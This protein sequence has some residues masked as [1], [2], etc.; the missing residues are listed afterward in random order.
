MGVIAENIAIV[1]RRIQR[2][3]EKAGRD[4]EEI[5]L[6]AVSKKV[7]A[8]RIQEALEAGI[9][10]FGENYVQEARE[11]IPQV[12]ADA[13]WH[14]VGHVQTNKAK[15]VVP[16]FVLIHSV[17]TVKLAQEISRQAEKLDK[18]MDI[19]IQVNISG[20]ESKSGVGVGT[21]L[22]LIQ[23]AAQL[24]HVGIQGL[25]TMPPFFDEPERA[26]PFFR[27]LRE[28]RDQLLPLLPSSVSLPHLSM[29]MSGDFE[30][31]V[32]EGATLVRIGTAIFGERRK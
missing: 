6:V 31:A 16:D 4:P 26:R 1:R 15:Y 21:A 27:G 8:A 22:S 2:A 11:K 19:L 3:A 29:G 23:E 10:I 7:D 18:I 20:E 13:Q 24:K 30:V 14:M 25:M 12:G 32:E 17:D 9:T 28:L 5:T